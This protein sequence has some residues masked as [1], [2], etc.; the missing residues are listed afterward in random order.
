[1]TPEDLRTA[2]A[3]GREQRSTE[4]KGPGMRT[5]KALL[6]KVIRA[7]LGMANKPDGGVVVLGVEDSGATITATGLSP[8]ELA[9]WG[10]DDLASSVSNYADPYIE[11]DVTVVNLDGNQFVAAEISGG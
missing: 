7:M 3:L 4:F 8:A 9:T 1:M 6:V 11:F 10:Y 5:D 2:I